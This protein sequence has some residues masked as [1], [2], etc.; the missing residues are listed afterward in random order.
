MRNFLR[1]LP[2]CMLCG[3]VLALPS[4]QARE[5]QSTVKVEA[6]PDKTI[7]LP[8]RDLTLFG[9]AVNSEN[10]TLSYNWKQIEGPVPASFSA[11]WALTTTVS[12]TAAGT[13]T[14]EL[15]A[16]SGTGAEAASRTT[17]TVLAADSQTSFYV[18]PTA[19]ARG[20]DGTAVRPWKSLIR[21]NWTKINKALASNNVI[22]YFSAR[23]A[24]A[25]QSEIEHESIDL[26]RTD[27]SSHRLTLDGMSRYN[28]SDANPSWQDYSGSNKFHID[29]TKGALSIGVQSTNP[30]NAANYTTIRGFE[31]SGASGRLVWGGRSSTVEYVHSHDVTAV[32]SSIM[33]HAAVQGDCTPKFGNLS[34]ITVRNNVIERG[35]GEAIY[36]AGNYQRAPD[37][38]CP[39]WGNTHSDI[40][41]EG[42]TIREPGR[43]GE[44]GDGIDLKAG[45]KNVTIRRNTIERT[46]SQAWGLTSEGTFDAGTQSGGYLIEQNIFLNATGITMH[47]ANGVVIRNNLIAPGTIYISGAGEGTNLNVK[48]YNNTLAGSGRG[49]G[50]ISLGGVTGADVRNNLITGVP[51]SAYQL[52]SYDTKSVRSDYNMLVKGARIDNRFGAGS[53]SQYL[54]PSVACFVDAAAGDYRLAAAS[55]AVDAGEDLKATGFD[56]DLS[57]NP[58]PKGKAWDIGAFESAATAAAPLKK[59]F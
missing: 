41:I 32:S 20:N 39:S 23:Q 14:F 6:G 4:T 29:V 53:H 8:V 34:D 10:Q 22:V 50:G 48:I 15:S 51:A 7:A 31:V 54:D 12:F 33:F 11:P 25:D 5:L 26:W 47:H 56:N 16:G 43:N 42:N 2:L 17:V 21:D 46:S 36:I 35:I 27:T 9:H 30:A 58:R 28:T 44:E 19:V 13:Y 49:D 59:P 45:L 52:N 38:G 3:L 18:D 1:R 57:G 55:A 24:A 37:G 40:L